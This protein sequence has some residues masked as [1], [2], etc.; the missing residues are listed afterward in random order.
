MF[1]IFKEYSKIIVFFAMLL[2][3]V[4]YCGI[5]LV[6]TEIHINQVPESKNITET[7]DEDL[8]FVDPYIPP[9][10][11]IFGDHIGRLTWED[12]KMKFE[13]NAYESAKIFFD[14]FLVMYIDDYIE[15]RMAEKEA[16]KNQVFTVRLEEGLW[17]VVEEKEPEMILFEFTAKGEFAKEFKPQL[18]L[19]IINT[20]LSRCFIGDSLRVDLNGEIYWIRLER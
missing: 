16:I 18:F 15:A 7:N 11:I 20:D 19:K 5:R 17:V 12:G 9:T 6:N 13:G 3:A 10:S 14:Y 2:I 8:L 1:K 4:I